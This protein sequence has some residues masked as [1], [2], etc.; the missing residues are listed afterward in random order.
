MLLS[1]FSGAG[2]L[3]LG[4]EQAG[5]NVAL[6]FDLREDSIK[7]YNHNRA[8]NGDANGHVFD[9]RNLDLNKL[10]ELYQGEFAPFGIIGGPPCQSFSRANKSKK[11][12]D[13][14]H[15]LPN[16]YANLI[17]E[18]NQRSPVAFFAFENVTGILEASHKKIFD[19][20]KKKLSKDFV[21]SE[22]VLNSVNYS[23]PQTRERLILVGL[24]KE[25]FGSMQWTP[26]APTTVNIDELNL[27]NTFKNL[28]EP[29][30]FKRNLTP[31]DIAY[32]KNH[33]CM[34]PKSQKFKIEGALKPGDRSN[35]SFKILS[36]DSPSITVAYGNR[37]VHI[38]PGCHRRL[39]V[40]EAMLLQ[41]FPPSYELVGSLSSQITQVSEAVPPPMACAIARSIISHIGGTA[42]DEIVQL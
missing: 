29:T 42:M 25:L 38:H 20:F 14:R 27:K 4:F 33:W 8:L 13:P 41:G 11:Q 32:H 12:D 17:L 18:L 37:E 9:V 34:Q 40:Y 22:S 5:F 15:E 28:P 7:S 16:V 3:D 24:N 6:A 35:R 21:L 31:E 26:P 36:W 10:D 19:D 1:L 39:S 2:G 23:V 30:Y